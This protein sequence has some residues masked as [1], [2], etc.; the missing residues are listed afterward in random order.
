[1]FI[2]LYNISLS[3]LLRLFLLLL[4]L[5][6]RCYYYYIICLSNIVIVIIIDVIINIIAY[7]M[8]YTQQ[9]H[10]VHLVVIV[11]QRISYL[12]GG[13]SHS[14]HCIKLSNEFSTALWLSNQ[15]QFP[16]LK[17]IMFLTMS[18][19]LQV[20]PSSYTTWD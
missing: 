5:L 4:L 6:Y 17:K 9:Y 18:N 14:S 11:A 1:M 8:Y 19:C 10:N 15:T 7:S 16:S 20:L 2:S 12:I 3:S 13:T